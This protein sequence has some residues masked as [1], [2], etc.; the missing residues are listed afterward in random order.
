M[1]LGVFPVQPDRSL[2]CCLVMVVEKL[3]SIAGDLKCSFRLM[4]GFSS[5]VAKSAVSLLRE[6]GVSGQSEG[7]MVSDEAVWS[8]LWFWIR[9]SNSSWEPSRGSTWD[10]RTLGRSREEIQDV[11]KWR[12]WPVWAFWNQAAILGEFACMALFLLAFLVIVGLFRWVCPAS[13]S[14]TLYT[15]I[16]PYL[17]QGL[18]P[19]Q[20][21]LVCSWWEAGVADNNAAC[22]RKDGG[23]GVRSSGGCWT[24][25]EVKKN[26]ANELVC[27]LLWYS[28]SYQVVLRP[29]KR[30]YCQMI[31]KKNT[32][33]CIKWTVC[34]AHKPWREFSV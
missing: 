1:Y 23:W 7:K 18:N 33:E 34:D 20:L 25:V 32:K 10:K 26:A 22:G 11:F 21:W 15:F 29:P 24:A 12:V 19:H 27:E 2:Y 13:T 9:R 30:S 28:Q 6:L 17:N 3:S 4:E 31:A 8:S 5:F 14:G 16:T